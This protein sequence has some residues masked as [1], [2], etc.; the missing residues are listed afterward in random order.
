MTR[1]FTAPVSRRPQRGDLSGTSRALGNLLG[2]SS[3]LI[4]ACIAVL[5]TAKGLGFAIYVLAWALIPKATADSEP[6]EERPRVWRHSLGLILVTAGVLQLCRYFGLWFS[7][8]TALVVALISFGVTLVWERADDEER[9]GIDDALAKVMGGKVPD[10]NKLGWVRMF[11]AAIFVASGVGVL[12]V[13]GL[14]IKASAVMDIVIAIALTMVGVATLAIPIIQ[15][16]TN[17]AEEARHERVRAEERADMAAH[18]HDSVLQTLALVQ[19]THDPERIHQLARRQERELRSWLFSDPQTE[20]KNVTVR[21]ALEAMA[22]EIEGIW[23]VKVEL[24]V[25]GDRP[26]N[27]ASDQVI[28]AVSEAIVNA[29][30]HAQVQRIDVFADIKPESIGIW[31]RDEGVG[32]DPQAIEASRQGVRNSIIGRLER[33]NGHVEIYSQLGEGTEVEI[34]CPMPSA[35]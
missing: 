27:D 18:L 26:M 4:R 22:S 14:A 19:R 3:L 2:V 8:G 12:V 33:L 29:A 34:S 31:V 20:R 30:K 5:C 32:F 16:A 11:L 28:A 10:L 1:F 21:E 15:Q 25:V 7:D 17:Q 24:V 9:R 35:D 13:N 23:P 6:E